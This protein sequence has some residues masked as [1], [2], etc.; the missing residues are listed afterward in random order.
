M[1]A[2]L[3]GVDGGG[4]EVAAGQVLALRL[5]QQ[6]R[7]LQGRQGMERQSARAWAAGGAVI[8]NRKSF[9]LQQARFCDPT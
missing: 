7:G 2:H 1:R 3:E 5:A 4:G 6:L 9:E 8:G